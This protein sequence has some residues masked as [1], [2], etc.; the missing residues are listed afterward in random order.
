MVSRSHRNAHPRVRRRFADLVFRRQLS[1]VRGGQEGATRR[2]RRA[3]APH[4]V[5][6]AVEL[7]LLR[8]MVPV[9]VPARVGE[10]CV[11]RRKVK[12]FAV[13]SFLVVVPA[14]TGT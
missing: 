10:G 11:L 1:G 5:Q 4:S 14:K 12:H 7:S 2:R 9:W 3:A 6:G 13:L 8:G